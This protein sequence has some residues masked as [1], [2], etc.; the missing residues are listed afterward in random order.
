MTDEVLGPFS[1]HHSGSI[2]QE[3]HDP[4][5]KIISWTT[6][7]W[8]AQVIMK[9]LNENQELLTKET[10]PCFNNWVF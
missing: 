10:N 1:V 9:L 4:D 2:G 7:A 3:I 5:G 8:V 6:N